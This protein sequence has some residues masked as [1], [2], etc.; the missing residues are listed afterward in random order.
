VA[1]FAPLLRRARKRL[2]SRR[3]GRAVWSVRAGR[4]YCRL[5]LSGTKGRNRVLANCRCRVGAVRA[6]RGRGAGRA[7]PTIPLSFLQHANIAFPRGLERGLGW[8]IVTPWM[9]RVHHSTEPSRT[10]WNYGAVFAPRDRLFGTCVRSPG[11][12]GRCMAISETSWNSACAA[13]AL[14]RARISPCPRAGI[15]S[16]EQ[17]PRIRVPVVLGACGGRGSCRSSKRN[18]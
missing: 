10:N 18:G 8:R 14:P 6:A 12:R 17:R 13:S 2:R 16:S 3:C 15:N 1:Q 5:C 9:H 7:P 11:A 4:R